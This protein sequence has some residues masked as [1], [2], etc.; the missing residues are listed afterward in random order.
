[1][2]VRL[3]HSRLKSL[4]ISNMRWIT[5]REKVTGAIEMRVHVDRAAQCVIPFVVDV[6][7]SLLVCR[8]PSMRGSWA[9]IDLTVGQ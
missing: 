4:L 8:V 2:Q 9:Y 6:E 5:S 7:N 3:N 1:M